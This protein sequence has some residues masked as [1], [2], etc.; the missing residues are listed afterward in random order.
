A[1]LGD[2]RELNRRQ[3]VIPEGFDYTRQTDDAV[4]AMLA[5][6]NWS[7]DHL[8]QAAGWDFDRAVFVKEMAKLRKEPL[9][10]MGHDRVLT[11]FSAH[12]PTLFKYL[13]QT[14]AEVTNPPID[15][16]REGGAMSLTTYLGRAAKVAGTLRVPLPQGTSCPAGTRSVPPTSD[17]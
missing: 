4:G 9:S 15:P 2:L 3:I 17:E 7:L 16:Y 6:R 11:V 13:Q 12:H 10:S 14:F 8:L 5:E 1:E